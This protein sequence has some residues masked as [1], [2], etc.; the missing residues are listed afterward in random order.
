MD[1]IVQEEK[2]RQEQSWLPCQNKNFVILMD[3]CPQQ[4]ILQSVENFETQLLKSFWNYNKMCY[5]DLLS[6]FPYP[7]ASVSRIKG[8][9][10]IQFS[11]VHLIHRPV[12][13]TPEK[14]RRYVT[15]SIVTKFT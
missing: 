10:A 6:S 9:R 1:H 4:N 3:T 12:A 2:F 5:V 14:K 13:N 8:V 11:S 15:I 7:P